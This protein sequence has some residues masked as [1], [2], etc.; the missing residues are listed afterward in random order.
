M[1]SSLV[2]DKFLRNNAVYFFATMTAAF[3]SYLLHPILTRLLSLEDYGE[4]Q[5]TLSFYGNL[6]IFLGLFS[7]IT[8][9]VIANIDEHDHHDQSERLRLISSLRSLATVIAVVLFIA[10]MVSSIWLKGFFHFRSFFPFIFLALAFLVGVPTL[11]RRAFLSGTKDFRSLGVTQIM[12]TG[13]RLIFAGL[14]AYAGF[15]VGGVMAGIVLSQCVVLGFVYARTRHKLTFDQLR[16][17]FGPEVRRELRFAALILAVSVTTSLLYTADVLVVKHF[18]PP[19]VAGEYGGI[20]I[21]ARIVM[22]VAGPLVAVLMPTVRL[23]N[24]PVENQ[25]LLF[26]TLVLSV[27]L[28]GSVLVA[29]LILPRFIITTLIGARF[30]PSAHLLPKLSLVMFLAALLNP[31]FS[32]Y[33]A[34]RQRFVAFIGIAGVALIIGLCALN[35]STPSVIIGNFLIGQ[36]LIMAAFAA[37]WTGVIIKHRLYVRA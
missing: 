2:K 3:L 37:R 1:L 20:A 8:V 34:L 26:K 4:V 32:Y 29:F 17:S 6:A 22:Y 36:V 35:H 12:D 15:R 5:A 24:A 33:L 18:F 16:L 28:G 23:R 9:N 10:V 31:I 21:V 30:L 25:K 14:L 13:S 27:L 11:F 7:S 19:T